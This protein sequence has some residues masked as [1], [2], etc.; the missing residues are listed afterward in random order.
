MTEWISSNN[1]G[2][3]MRPVSGF[4]ALAVLPFCSSCSGAA[5][6][7]AKPGPDSRLGTNSEAGADSQ[8]AAD[9]ASQEDSSSAQAD[10]GA[11][12]GPGGDASSALSG[13][14]T[15]YIESFMFPDGSDTIV[16]TLTFNDDG[17]VTGTV[18]FGTAPLLAPPTDASVG[19]PPGYGDGIG[20]PG[21]P[22]APREGFAFTVL[23]GTYMMAP[24]LQLQVEPNELWKQWCGLQT[25]IYPFCNCGQTSCGNYA[26]LPNGA[27]T[28][29]TNGCQ[30]MPCTQTQ[31]IVVDCGKFYL[32]DVGGPCV[33]TA[34]GCTV[35]V[36]PAGSIKFDTQ[37]ISGSINGSV[38]GLDNGQI[39]SV[40]LTKMQ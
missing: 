21:P 37:L 6:T 20:P 40:H 14:Y 31:P 5:T 27:T 12:D 22:A 2:G 17:T 29:G 8:A 19:Y 16:F 4:V 38:T 25:T 10:S 33:C 39:L 11:T 35:V 32:C 13:V 24:R 15:G 26:C 30:V 9:V 3:F 34:T 28:S 23:S 18:R 36:G 7:A 1:T